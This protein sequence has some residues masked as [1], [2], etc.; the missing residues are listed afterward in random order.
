MR[1]ARTLRTALPVVAALA[2]AVPAAAVAS[3]EFFD[4]LAEALT[5]SAL[6]GA[7]R[8]RLSGT[9]DLEGYHLPSPAPAL[10]ETTRPDLFN[11]RLS[12]FLDAQ[13]GTRAYGFAQ[14][15]YHVGQIRELTHRT[16]NRIE[17]LGI[18]RKMDKLHKVK[19]D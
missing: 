15:R 16:L 18:R 14:A 3:E 10:F 13:L 6:D 12:L 1:I 11:P 19:E 9:L 4:R 17:S 5:T 8:A 2:L 7:F